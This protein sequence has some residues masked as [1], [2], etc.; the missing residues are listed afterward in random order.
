MK[1][2]FVKGDKKVV[3][4]WAIYDW[5]NSVYH[6]VITS[7]L[8]PIY[9]SAVTHAGGAERVTFLGMSFLPDAL[10]TYA[11]SFAFLVIAAVSPLLSG[12]AD[13]SG[14]KKI[15]MKFFCYMGAS[16]CSLLFFFTDTSN[17]WL[18]ITMVIFACIGYA[19]SIV[20][21]NAYLPEIVDH[22]EQD[23]VSAKGF[24]YGY[25]GSSILLII[26]LIMVEMPGWTGLTGDAATTMATRC[27]FLTVGIWWVGFAQITFRRLPTNPLG[28]VKENVERH[29]FK[30]YEELLKVWRMLK[31]TKRLRRFLIAF[32]IYNTG[33]RTI[34]L[35]ANLFGSDTLHLKEGQL[36]PTILII[37]FVAVG[38]AYIF[39][40]IAKIK[41][42]IYMLKWA[43]FIWVGVCIGAYFTYTAYEFYALAFFVGLVMGGIQALSRSTYS[44]M[45]PP[46]EDHASFFS[47]YDVC[48]NVGS[49]LG[50][51][52]YGWVYDFTHDMRN[53]IGFLLM[54]FVFGFILLNR[55]PKNKLVNA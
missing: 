34:M 24:S 48:E 10:Y 53:S 47:F 2:A 22:H 41:S 43:V 20:F 46:T 54:L 26:N 35:V 1:Q 17:L 28:E 38:G 52:L 36:I 13:Y 9:Y 11:L 15:F 12:I 3:N 25:I 7:T 27:S 49:V 39:S 45:L 31:T 55:I 19:G 14:N 40:H 29:I 18:G 51:F 4:A 23:K 16:A 8:F 6:L 33:V 42:D 21:Y 32:F 5:A 44:K 30:G 50:L 37:Q